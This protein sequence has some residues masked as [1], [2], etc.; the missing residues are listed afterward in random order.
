MFSH[1]FFKNFKYF[2]VRHLFV[3]AAYNAA[4]VGNFFKIN[5]FVNAKFSQSVGIPISL[6]KSAR[7]STPAFASSSS[8]LPSL[9]IPHTLTAN[10]AAR[11][12]SV[13]NRCADYKCVCLGKLWRNLVYNIVKYTFTCLRAFSVSGTAMYVFVSHMDN[14]RIN[15]L[16]SSVFFNSVRTVKVQPFVLGLPFINNAFIYTSPIILKRLLFFKTFSKI[17]DYITIFGL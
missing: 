2:L 7:A 6:I 3:T 17:N 1:Y 10:C 4:G 14:F 12:G 8:V 15:A 13:I 9:E 11:R 5:I 16:F